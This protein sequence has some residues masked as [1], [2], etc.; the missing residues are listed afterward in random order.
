MIMKY[1]YSVVIV[2]PNP[3]AP[4]R[5]VVSGKTYEEARRICDE[6]NRYDVGGISVQHELRAIGVEA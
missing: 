3:K 6:L 5:E 4:E 1:T 2:Y